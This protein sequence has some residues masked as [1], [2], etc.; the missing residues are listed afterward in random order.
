[1]EDQKPFRIIIT[2]EN[3]MEFADIYKITRSYIERGQNIPFSLVTRLYEI[4]YDESN[5]KFHLMWDEC[6][7]YS[8]IA[9]EKIKSMK[10]YQFTWQDRLLPDGTTKFTQDSKLIFTELI[11]AFSSYKEDY[12]SAGKDE[13]IAFI[14]LAFDEEYKAK[15]QTT[16]QVNLTI[17]KQAVIAGILTMALGYQLSPNTNPSNEEIFQATR[18]AIHKYKKKKD[19][20]S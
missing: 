2:A 13:A 14:Y 18:N 1:M 11:Y 10:D 20:F 17:Y 4:M 9:I 19:L 15:I 16:D 6:G 12:A 7:K 5:Y 8:E 3:K